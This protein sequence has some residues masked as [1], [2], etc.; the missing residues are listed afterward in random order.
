MLLPVHL[1][2]MDDSIM[3]RTRRDVLKTITVG[4]VGAVALSGA[5]A[6]VASA[7][8]PGG[9]RAGGP[10]HKAFSCPEGATYVKYEL[11]EN[12]DGTC[13][14]VEETDTGIFGDSL[15]VTETKDGDPCEPLAVSWDESGFVATSVMAF[16]G[17]DCETVPNPAG[18]YNADPNS[19]DTEPNNDEDAGLDNPGGNT[20]AISNLQFCVGPDEPLDCPPGTR[21]LASYDV[22]DG[23]FVFDSGEDVVEFS[24][25]VSD[26][27]GVKGFDFSSIDGSDADSAPEV[28][29][30]VTVEFG[31]NVE[32]FEV[33]PDFDVDKTAGTVDLTDAT[34]GISSVKFCQGVY[35]QVDFVTGDVITDLCEDQYSSRRISAISWG[36]YEGQL[37]GLAGQFD[38][39]FVL[40]ADG[41]VTVNY[42]PADYDEKVALAVYEVSDP[43]FQDNDF[44]SFADT[45]CRQTLVDAETDEVGD[46]DG[47]LTADLPSLNS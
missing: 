7:R 38:G 47:T 15:T 46:Q 4:G 9:G 41:T 11:V 37:D 19:R 44:I 42:D 40:N 36:S 43:V 33:D 28:L 25:I 29:T 14:F 3:T 20:A 35:A 2:A 31:S 22:N 32:T 17:E 5:G 26:S 34:D 45:R 39:G 6:G 12:D 10:C 8:G 16:G 18:A 30:T 24:N 27:D 1:P 13:Q 23:G 21:A